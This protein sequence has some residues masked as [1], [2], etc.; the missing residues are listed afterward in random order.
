METSHDG[1]VFASLTEWCHSW[2]QSI[3]SVF[4]QTSV[5]FD[6]T[7]TTVYYNA[8]TS[9]TGE[10]AYSTVYKATQAFTS[11]PVYALKRMLIQSNEM[12]R[13]AN[14]EIEAYDRFK[15]RNILELI[16]HTKATENNRRVIYLL[17]PFMERGSL[18]D[19]VGTTLRNKH[20]LITVLSRFVHFCEALNVLHT[21]QPPY[22]H[23]D[24]KLEVSHILY[25]LFHLHSSCTVLSAQLKKYDISPFP[26]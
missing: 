1:D 13:I 7:G 26:H 16:A 4:F 5:T 24:I 17:F 12:E 19:S 9:S 11:E 23:Q 3:L 20:T 21:F 8:G 14:I 2:I 18:R 15:H 25:C 6:Q 22:V 10:G